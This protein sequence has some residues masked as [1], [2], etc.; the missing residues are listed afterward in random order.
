MSSADIRRW[1]ENPQLVAAMK[2][3]KET[4]TPEAENAFAAC[5]REARFLAPV[6]FDPP[7][8]KTGSPD[9][10]VTL[11]EDTRISYLLL[12][13]A[14]GDSFFPAF[15]SWGEFYKWGRQP[16]GQTLVT[17]FDDYCAMILPKTEGASGFVIDPFGENILLRREMMLRL[18]SEAAFQWKGG[19]LV[20]L[21]QPK[22]FPAELAEA[23]KKIL[24]LQKSVH[25]AYLHLMIR[26]QR[27]SYLLVL[28]FLEDADREKICDILAEAAK[29][30]LKGMELN[31]VSLQD[32]LGQKATEG[33]EP[34][35][36]RKRF[37]LF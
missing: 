35:Y 28:D 19:Q 14:E 18:K 33:R 24:K 10:K 9:G 4:G 7:L 30:Y 21:G 31:I 22:E 20:S 36:V 12:S 34:F 32:E 15:T 16:K 37:G 6:I 1:P 5:L 23:A 8:P 3:M 26:D 17:S 11:K 2:E 13:L 27:Q 25:K 29:P